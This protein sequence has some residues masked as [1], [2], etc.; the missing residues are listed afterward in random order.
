MEDGAR[1]LEPEHTGDRVQGFAQMRIPIAAA[2]DGSLRDTRRTT[3]TAADGL[4]CGAELLPRVDG[5]IVGRCEQYSTHRGACHQHHTTTARGE[6]LGQGFGVFHRT[7]HGETHT[8]HTVGV[9]YGGIPM[10]ECVVRREC[11]R[12][13]L[14]LPFEILQTLLHLF[15]QCRHVVGCGRQRSCSPREQIRVESCALHRT[16][17]AN[18]LD[19]C[20]PAGAFGA[21]QQHG[22]DFRRA[23]HMCATTGTAIESV[24]GHDAQRA[25]SITGL[26]QPRR[27]FSVFIAHRYFEIV[28]CQRVGPLLDLDQLRRCHLGRRHIHRGSDVAEVH[29]DGGPSVPISHQR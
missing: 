24:D 28:E 16:M 23:R 17:S 18:K 2:G 25:R 20:M 1:R 4:Q 3:T 22:A 10:R 12:G 8:A 29:T 6:L 13:A 7:I 27:R 5:H 21:A 14:E 26:A 15:D 11:E 19:A 9:G